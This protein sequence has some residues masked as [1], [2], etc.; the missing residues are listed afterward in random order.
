MAENEF[1]TIDPEPV[2]WKDPEGEWT[3]EGEC[4]RCGQCCIDCPHLEMTG[5]KANC[6]IHDKLEEPCE[7]CSKDR[8]IE[9]KDGT[10]TKRWVNHAVCKRFPNH[11]YLHVIKRGICGYRFIKV[12]K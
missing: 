1:P 3:R 12:K 8:W 2:T 9:K 6:L 4:N 10:R 5:G 11:P 7:E